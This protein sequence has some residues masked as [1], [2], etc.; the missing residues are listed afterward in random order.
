MTQLPRRWFKITENIVV[1]I[2]F[3]LKEPVAL[4]E[5]EFNIEDEDD[6]QWTPEK[7]K[8]IAIVKARVGAMHKEFKFDPYNK[9]EANQAILD[10]IH[11]C[12]DILG[13]PIMYI[14]LF[15][16]FIRCLM[17]WK[18]K[19]LWDGFRIVGAVPRNAEDMSR[20]QI[21]SDW[22]SI[23]RGFNKQ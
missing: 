7:E 6:G 15:G 16:F 9:E 17:F 23:K 21:D 19:I 14:S 3:G 13:P 5:A 4:I 10:A 22:E 20:K 8:Q 12:S 2:D 18:Y 11:W 1:C